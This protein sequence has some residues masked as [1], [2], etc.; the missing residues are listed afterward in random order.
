MSAT[1]FSLVSGHILISN[2]QKIVVSH[3][4]CWPLSPVSFRSPKIACV[5][6]AALSTCWMPWHNH[7][8]GISQ[9]SIFRFKAWNSCL[10]YCGSMVTVDIVSETQHQ[11]SIAKDSPMSVWIA[12]SSASVKILHER[13]LLSLNA[14]WVEEVIFF[15]RFRVA[16]LSF[17]AMVVQQ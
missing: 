6:T 15:D 9:M 7:I 1:L 3:A 11:C 14:W 13:W 12:P 5:A 17:I 16:V 2:P 10:E 4:Y 8:N